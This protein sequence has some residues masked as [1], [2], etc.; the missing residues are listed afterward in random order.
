MTECYWHI[1][2]P[3]SAVKLQDRWF[4]FLVVLLEPLL[5]FDDNPL[6]DRAVKPYYP[7]GLLPVVWRNVNVMNIVS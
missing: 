2:R 7:I 5:L 6:L 3:A 1:V 4:G